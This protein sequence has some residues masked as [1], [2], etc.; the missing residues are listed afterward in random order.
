MK[1]LQELQQYYEDDLCDPIFQYTLKGGQIIQIRFFRESFCHLLGIQHIVKDRKFIGKKGYSNIASG[2]LTIQK[3][4]D[5]NRSSF[6]RMRPRMKYFD[7]INLLMHSGSMFK[8]YPD[9]VPTQSK[10]AADFVLH[11]QDMRIYLHLFLAKEQVQSVLYAP[12]SYI[13]LT[14]KDD[15]PRNYIQGQEFKDVIEFK[16]IED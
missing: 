6:N 13:P 14:E 8:F 7:R 3:L 5:A 16:I 2:R 4:R 1:S 15:N 12:M 11:E 10:I 9:R